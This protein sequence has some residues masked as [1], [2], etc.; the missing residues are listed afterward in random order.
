MYI[1]LYIQHIYLKNTVHKYV[2]WMYTFYKECLQL[3]T[4][5]VHVLKESTQ[6]CTFNIYNFLKN[7]H[8]SIHLKYTNILIIYIYNSGHLIYTFFKEFTQ[9][10]TF[11][12]YNFQI[13]YNIIYI[14]HEQ[15]FQ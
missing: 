1:I 9:F 8:N 3:W 13:M 6:F 2:Q 11:N 4:F 10:C 12:I 5:N 14:Q 15:I 7:V